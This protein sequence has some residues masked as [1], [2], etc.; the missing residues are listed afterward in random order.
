MQ[1]AWNYIHSVFEQF[2]YCISTIQISDIIDIL[3]VAFL[4][5]KSIE[6]FRETRAGTLIKGIII[7]LIIYALSVW[8]DMV[9]LKWLLVKLASVAIIAVAVVFQPELRRALE[10]VGRS[11]I[12]KFTKSQG[13]DNW[14]AMVVESIECI[15]KS[16]TEMQESKTGAL[17]VLERDTP[18][19]EIIDTG[20]VL[21]AET[22]VS[23]ISSVFFPKSPLHDGA[24][25]MRDGK[26]YAAG[27][28]LPLTSNPDLSS[29]LGTRHRA[30]IGVSEVSDAIVVV[31][32]EE[33]GTISV[34]YN[35]Q[36]ERGFNG[37]SLK[38]KL[39]TMITSSQSAEGKVGILQSIKDKLFK[40]KEGDS[41]DENE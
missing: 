10:R 31:V 20:T 13:Y 30:A 24:L 25:I 27:C 28:I 14:T 4:I 22:S 33:T 23:L 18:L 37:I 26:T 38:E 19:G 29:Q 40:T 35:G 2:L 15:C 41:K 36:I 16:A 39:V 17:I 5:Y 8:F 9:V 11:K 32:S 34:A 21:N 7:V 6:L 3:I 1:A 12:G